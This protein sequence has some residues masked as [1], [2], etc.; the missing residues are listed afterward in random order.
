MFRNRTLPI[1]PK[2]Q[3]GSMLVIAIFIM[4]VMLLIGAAMV[5][6]LATSGQTVAYEVSGTRAYLAANSGAQRKLLEIFPLDD[7]VNNGQAK[8]C[9]GSDLLTAPSSTSNQTFQLVVDHNKNRC[10]VAV[11]CEDFHHDNVTYYQIASTATCDLGADST[12]RTVII[13]ARSL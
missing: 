10:N 9:D 5:N 7:G 3:S 8:M 6:I 13:E 2:H 1:G 4:V 11:S 12:S